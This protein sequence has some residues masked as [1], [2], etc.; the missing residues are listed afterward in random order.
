MTWRTMCSVFVCFF[1]CNFKHTVHTKGSGHMDKMFNTYMCIAC[2]PGNLFSCLKGAPGHPSPWVHGS[3][4]LRVAVAGATRSSPW[5]TRPPSRSPGSTSGAGAR[6]SVRR[7]CC[8]PGGHG[9]SREGDPNVPWMRPGST[10]L[11]RL[12]TWVLGHRMAPGLGD[13]GRLVDWNCSCSPANFL[14]GL[15]GF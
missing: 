1:K 11:G 7:C 10:W 3:M 2:I 14:D 12:G 15:V 8:V 4:P 13:V 6:G 5:S 9:S